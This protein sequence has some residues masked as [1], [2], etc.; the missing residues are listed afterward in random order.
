[1][2]KLSLDLIKT[3]GPIKTSS[4]VVYHAYITLMAQGLVKE[5]EPERIVYQTTGGYPEEAK[6]LLVEGLVEDL[7]KL[8]NLQ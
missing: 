3:E 7:K 8:C 5:D 2:S 6:R 4:G 1:M